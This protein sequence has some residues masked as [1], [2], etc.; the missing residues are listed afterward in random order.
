M[1]L[2]APMLL[3]QRVW[4]TLAAGAG[5]VVNIGSSG[6]IGDAAYGSPE[7]GA[8]KA[9]SAGSPPASPPAATYE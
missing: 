9:G 7:Y 3:T 6:G 5:A 1:N 8:A 4:A 2:V